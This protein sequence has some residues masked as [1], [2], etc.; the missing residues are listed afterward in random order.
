MQSGPTTYKNHTLVHLNNP[1]SLRS[2]HLLRP[3]F[4]NLQVLFIHHLG[5]WGWTGRGIASN[6]YSCVEGYISKGNMQSWETINVLEYIGRILHPMAMLVRG[7]GELQPHSPP[8]RGGKA[9]SPSP[10]STQFTSKQ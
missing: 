1:W 6:S 8:Q 7:M 9:I 3:L 5:S 4:L 10:L 2:P